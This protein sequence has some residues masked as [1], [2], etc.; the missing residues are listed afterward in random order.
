MKALVI[1]SGAREHALAWALRRSP[2]VRDVMV[3]PGNAG[4]A[5]IARNL[6]IK[7]DDL[8]GLV[9]FARR[10]AVDLTVVGPEG[11]LILGVVDRF[12]EAG[13]VCYG[14]PRAAARLEGSK[15]FAKEFMQRHRIPTAEFAVFE[16]ADAA[17]TFA[18]KLGAPVVV[19]ADGLAAGKGVVVAADLA[20][21]ERAIDDML[22]GGRFGAAGRRVVVEEFLDGEEVSV[23]A[24]C[25]GVDAAL[26]PASQDHKRAHDGDRGPNTGGMGAIAPVPWVTARDME[27]VRTNIIMPVLRGMRDEGAPFTGTLY[28]GL[29]WTRMGPKVLEFNVRFG[30]PETEALMPLLA[31]DVAGLLHD[32][33][34]GKIPAAITTR[35]GSAAT[36]VVASRGYPEHAETGVAVEGTDEIRGDHVAVFHGGTRMQAGRMVSSGGRILAV[37]AWGDDLRGA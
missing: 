17:K 23:H 33:A 12:R 19:K 2:G 34:R 37:S 21:A 24:I 13:L 36:V 11:P 1:G 18:R 29:M 27:A 28:V 3:A 16:D 6:D 25:A 30:D 9:E 32:A 35:A 4:T 15:A 5:A 20:E 31:G 7:A 14:P 8:A 22:V 10:E 26:L